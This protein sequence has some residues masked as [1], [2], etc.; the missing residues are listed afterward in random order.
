V[1]TG[2]GITGAIVAGGASSR[3]GGEAKGLLHVGGQRIIDRIASALRPVV[4]TIAIVSNAPDAAEWLD[5]TPV[6]RDERGER[7]SMVGV[8]TALGH[9]DNVLVV[10][11]DM[12]FVSEALLHAIV[13]TLTPAVGAVVP[14]GPNGPQPMCALYTRD[15]L[16]SIDHALDAGDLRMTALVERLPRAARI[17][18]AEIRRLGDPERLFFNVNTADDLR[19]A[20]AMAF[21]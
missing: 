21:R 19:I 14:Q 17:S 16:E 2:A 1:S 15:C 9:A 7:A 10:A 8:H 13:N 11:W 3:F 12:P 5:G 4:E 6:W 20:E 18:L